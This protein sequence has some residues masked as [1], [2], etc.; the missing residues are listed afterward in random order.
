[1]RLATI[2][3]A[4]SLTAAGAVSAQNTPSTN[5]PNNIRDQKDAPTTA[6]PETNA[7]PN[8][9][10]APAAS[11]TVRPNTPAPEASERK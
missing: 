9:N 6:P 10:A 2:I 3:I 7:S 5:Q 4:A 8:Q 11:T 1:M